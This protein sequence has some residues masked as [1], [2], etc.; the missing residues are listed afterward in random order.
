MP[1]RW[2]VS[3]LLCLAGVVAAHAA[4]A[5]DVTIRGAQVEVDYAAADFGASAAL[6][7]P[8]VRRSG[9]IVSAYYGD[10]KSVV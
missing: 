4:A 2:F 3:V 5:A 8:W 7:L 6:L 9:E 10:R 1:R